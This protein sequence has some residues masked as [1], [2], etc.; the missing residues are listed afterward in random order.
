MTCSDLVIE[1]I[2]RDV[3]VKLGLNSL[4]VCWITR[5]VNHLP[6][7]ASSDFAPLRL[8][9]F[10]TA[11][12]AVWFIHKL[13]LI[14]CHIWATRPVKKKQNII[15]VVVTFERIC[16]QPTDVTPDHMR[17]HET[18]LRHILMPLMKK[19]FGGLHVIG[20]TMTDINSRF[21]WV[22]E[23]NLPLVQSRYNNNT[24]RDTDFLHPLLWVE[25]FYCAKMWLGMLSSILSG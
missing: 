21:E 4:N 1:F 3:Q 16:I 19:Y 9:G 23:K 11:S 10:E 20:S 22:P 15:F 8:S 25:S 18:R 13:T 2:L 7:F 6:L 14:N 24:D 12:E 5:L 17:S